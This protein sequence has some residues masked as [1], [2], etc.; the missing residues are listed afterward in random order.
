[1]K[2]NLLLLLLILVPLFFSCKTVPAQNELE[3]EKK[4]EVQEETV[5]EEPVTVSEPEIKEEPKAE[6]EFTGESYQVYFAPQSYKI[7]K[8]T[9]LR[10][11]EITESLKEKNVKKIIILGHSTKLDSQ[12]EEDSIALKRAISVANYFQKM[13]LFDADSIVVEGR[14]IDEPAAAHSEITERFKNRRVEIRSA[15]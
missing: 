9:A 15:E 13:Q 10:L 12:R 5:K 7:D 14:G 3:P 1:M 4:E 8:F 2:K 11:K 6:S